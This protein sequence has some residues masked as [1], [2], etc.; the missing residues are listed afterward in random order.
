M[1]QAPSFLSLFWT[2]ALALASWTATAAA[3][4]FTQFEARQTHSVAITPDGTRLLAL[5]SPAASLSVFDVSQ[6]GVAPVLLVEIPV[7]M[8]P[9]SVRVRTNDE[10]WVVN[11]VGDSVSIVSLSR[12]A[13]V[14]T[15]AA[16]D[17]PGD[18]VFAQGK[19]FVSCA[20]NRLLRVFDA[21]TRVETAPIELA[22]LDPRALAIDPSGAYVYA[23]FLLSGNRTTILSRN[24]APPQPDP[25]NPSLPVPPLTGLIVPTND[26]RIPQTV[27]DR[28]IAKI[29]AGTGQVVG[30][31]GG[32]GTILFDLA[33]HPTT[34]ELWVANT[35]AL[36][37]IRFEPVLRG[38]FADSRLTR[39]NLGSS[40]TNFVD[41]NAGTDYAML[42]NPAAQATALTQPTGLAFAPDGSLWVAAFASDRVARLDPSNGQILVRIDL[43]AE[44]DD[45][46]DMR[47][48]RSLAL[49][50]T[51]PRLFVLNKISDTLT[52]IATDT[53]AVT[54]EVPLSTTDWMPANIRSGRGFLFDA[55][56]SGNGTNSCAVCHVDAD[57]D[58]LAWDL[59][60]PNGQM[61]SVL[62]ANLAAH[63]LTPIPREM[64]PMKGPMVTQPLR[65]MT[66]G[67]PFHWRGDRATLQ[68]FNPT[69]AKLMGG[70]QLSGAD[71]NLMADY[72]FTLRHHPNPNRTKTGDLPPALP[73]DMLPVRG[74]VLFNTHDNHCGICHIPP[75][76]TD[77]NIDSRAEVGAEQSMKN[78]SLATVYQK[79]NFDPR[80]GRQS[81]SGFGLL[82]D[83]G[84]YELPTA[85]PY[86]LDTL[87]TAFDF[88]DV[89]AFVL[90]FETGTSNPVGDSTSVTAQ[91]AAGAGIDLARLE[92]MPTARGTLVVRGTI[93]GVPRKFI[94]SSIRKLYIS[95]DF[96][97][98][99]LTRAQLL[100]LLGPDD[101]LTF[102][103]VQPS[104]G[105]RFAG[106]AQ[107]NSTAR[108][109]SYFVRN[110][111]A[112][113][114][115]PAATGVMA[116]DLNV[117]A[118][119]DMVA[120]T[121]VQAQSP[122]Q[123][124]VTL[125][126]DGSF[127]YTPAKTFATAKRDRFFY[128]LLPASDPGSAA[129]AVQVTIN[130]MA[131]VAGRYNG[132]VR[133]D[134][135]QAI[136]GFAKISVSTSGSWSGSIKIGARTTA[137]K[138]TV[139]LNGKLTVTTKR[140][141]F[142]VDLT[143]SVLPDF[144]RQIALAVTYD[145]DLSSGILPGNPYSTKVKAPAAGKYKLTLSVGSSTGTAPVDPGSA[146]LVVGK[147]GTATISGKLGDKTKFSF[148]GVLA[149][150]ET[151]GW[152][153]MIYAAVYKY[154]PGSVAGEVAFDPVQPANIDGSLLTVKPA[155]TRAGPFQG[156]FTVDYDVAKT[157][158]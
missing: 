38:H 140:L 100:A 52:E 96:G 11:E 144:S 33:I 36:N 25:V 21:T 139:G 124:T 1:K 99:P 19:A 154:P 116:N 128:L 53:H 26:P 9:V 93:G 66:N 41:L 62:G 148:A 10:A 120:T 81:L 79:L 67:A 40:A 118:T 127:V 152:R 110:A 32:V 48:P 77:N 98:A 102:M 114:T 45:S 132:L 55:R 64:H 24:D 109:D 119:H 91:N 71:I 92:G 134:A 149:A 22:G 73:G 20:R 115:V 97:E 121:Q 63:I 43:R 108:T 14:A 107:R 155:Q 23:A 76:G 6:A 75:K 89:Q 46:T 70:L 141:A 37:L 103:G 133:L 65:G 27:L 158:P 7:G 60:D 83:G 157:A 15:L 68:S 130:T 106:T 131:S 104:E 51:Q 126:Q 156:G 117:D 111:T 153:F 86:V 135:S 150:T 29:D 80:P 18:V 143:L 30:Y 101:S 138:G 61:T 94:F 3:A 49:H 69:F 82:H 147:T 129:E 4:P 74:E 136:S 57:R 2:M 113:L 28:D 17:E 12:L 35:E 84:G 13:V 78:P 122:N 95:E 125:N 59:G 42:P 72:L 123:G 31:Y 90:C 88:I 54:I 58:G 142:P 151:G 39:L 50:P 44:G 145:G 5:N 105:G 137:V 146:S 8:E 16:S 56:L 112:P 87:K 47:G 85:H 34:G